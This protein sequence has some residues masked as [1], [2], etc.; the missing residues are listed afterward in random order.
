MKKSIKNPIFIL[1]L[2][3]VLTFGISCGGGGSSISTGETTTTAHDGLNGAAG[4]IPSS[5]LPSD[6]EGVSTYN[7]SI[8]NLTGH[9]VYAVASN[10]LVNHSRTNKVKFYGGTEA[11][12]VSKATTSNTEDSD[13]KTIVTYI[14]EFTPLAEKDIESISKNKTLTSSKSVAKA[15]YTVN[16]TSKDF[17]VD[18]SSSPITTKLRARQALNGQYLNIWVD[19]AIWTTAAQT[20]LDSIMNDFLLNGSDSIYTWVTNIFGSSYYNDSKSYLITDSDINIV[21]FN[22]NG[23]TPG[24]SRTL[25][26]F[27]PN[28]VYTY[29]YN[30]NSNEINGFY[31]D[32]YSLMGY[33]EDGD[34]WADATYSAIAHE[35]LH[36]IVF[37]QKY[38]TYGEYADAWL[39]EMLAMITEDIFSNK[40]GLDG[41]RG[42]TALDGSGSNISGRLSYANAT[43]LNRVSYD[44]NSTSDDI[45]YNTI[46]AFGAYLLR[47]YGT[48]LSVFKRI[49]QSDLDGFD[50]IES[51]I[52]NV[53]KSYD[54]VLNSAKG[55]ILSKEVF[56]EESKKYRYN[57]GT[58]GFT[59]ATLNNSFQVGS[60]NLYNYQ[61]KPYTY[62]V[63]DTPYALNRASSLLFNLTT[64]KTG[65]FN[66]NLS[67]PN[68]TK[69]EIIVLDSSGNYD[70]AKSG[71]VQVQKVE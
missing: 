12:V 40:L 33:G 55:M 69:V 4:Y 38:L 15:T 8:S 6:A 45:N 48:D 67:L 65:A 68:Y 3:F 21:L 10:Q 39:N 24:K 59:A 43:E 44:S 71:Q 31:I 26:Y 9:S 51:A 30:S 60:I 56:G 53:S 32:F 47:N 34:F 29:L 17:N 64:N 63:G 2:V 28:D 18:T 22:I 46:Y 20:K 11:N 14:P 52:G 13:V 16:I 35:F 36:S 5:T 37:Y 50:A 57:G 61:S 1:V 27:D 62:G 7:I 41:P 49:V 23:N 25:G 42:V 58:N 54:L 19:E 70:V 66:V